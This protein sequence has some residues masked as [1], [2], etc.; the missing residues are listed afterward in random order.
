M[1]ILFNGGH[2]IICISCTFL[3]CDSSISQIT[4]SMSNLVA[5][6]FRESHITVNP[7]K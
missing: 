4:L 2:Q 7:F 3:E 1:L 6:S 5:S